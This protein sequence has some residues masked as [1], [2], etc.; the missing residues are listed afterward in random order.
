MPDDTKRT[1]RAFTGGSYWRTLA[2]IDKLAKHAKSLKQVQWSPDE[3]M[4]LF[5]PDRMREP[6][7]Q[8]WR[9]LEGG[10][11]NLQT[12]LV[13]FDNLMPMQWEHPRMAFTFKWPEVRSGF[14]VPVRY[15]LSVSHPAALQ[16]NEGQL[17][18]KWRRMLEHE[19]RIAYEWGLV[20]HTFMT[21]NAA[22]A[23]TT[24]AQMRYLWPALVPILNVAGENVL[25]RQLAQASTRAG[26]KARCPPPLQPYLKQTFDIVAKGVL[27]QEV[28]SITVTSTDP[29]TYKLHEP[30]F[31][32]GKGVDFPGYS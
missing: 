6:M 7:T 13:G 4:H 22:D 3:L 31:T 8:A 19:M 29:I 5:M 14:M 1:T 25:A 9:L 23:C 12:L 30:K 24:P 16:T 17:Y 11:G 28:P 32:D 26:D 10:P 20:K 18:E 15:G 21:L 27:L 2:G